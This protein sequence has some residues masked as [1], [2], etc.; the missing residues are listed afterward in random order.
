MNF[1]WGIKLKNF[2]FIFL[3]SIFAS[4]SVAALDKR[5]GVSK[6]IETFQ[7]YERIRQQEFEAIEFDDVNYKIL[8]KSMTLKIIL[9]DQLG[10]HWLF[11]DHRNHGAI[12]VARLSYLMGQDMPDVLPFRLKI[13]DT[14]I[15]GSV[16]PFIE[17][18]VDFNG[19]FAD[20]SDRS[21]EYL[22]YMHYLSY[23]TL[24][25]HVHNHQF[26]TKEDKIFRIDNSINYSLI[27]DETMRMEYV[28]PLLNHD[29]NSGY[30]SFWKYIILMNPLYNNKVLAARKIKSFKPRELNFAQVIASARLI[31]QLPDDFFIKQFRECIQDDFRSCSNN[32]DYSDA[33][34]NPIGNLFF[35]PKKFSRLM[36]ERKNSGDQKLF[37]MYNGMFTELKDYEK[38]KALKN[39][40]VEGE[41]KRI[42]SFL[43]E[44]IESSKKNLVLLKEKKKLSSVAVLNL[45]PNFNYELFKLANELGL[46]RSHYSMADAIEHLASIKNRAMNIQV[47][48]EVV[49]NTFIHNIDVIEKYLR[50]EDFNKEVLWRRY[51]HNSY[52][53]LNEKYN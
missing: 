52:K 29:A 5:N 34:L 11:K 25:Y 43:N 39:V 1:I 47:H 38:A 26:I 48:N 2:I 33:R 46:V 30:V 10:K 18:V 23:I 9:T 19:S 12:T 7:E 8:D 4:E 14:V 13:M 27:N 37:K 35:D 50:R 44:K 49:K 51:L 17:N 31:K 28:T 42:I 24:N 21:I 6:L 53:L 16:Q 41:A 40:N 45:K 15:E 20:L 3:I 32:F 36:L 22:L